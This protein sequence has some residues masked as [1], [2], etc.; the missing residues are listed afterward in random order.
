MYKNCYS[1]GIQY[2]FKNELRYTEHRLT[3]QIEKIEQRLTHQIERIE[4]RLEKTEKRLSD[5]FEKALS[6]HRENIETRIE[7]VP[8]VYLRLFRRLTPR[9]SRKNA[10]IQRPYKPS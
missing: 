3:H 6:N 7:V 4:Q 10:Q 5:Q 9:S 8:L 1:Y 2:D